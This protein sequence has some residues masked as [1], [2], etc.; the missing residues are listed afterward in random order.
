MAIDFEALFQ[1]ADNWIRSNVFTWPALVQ[2][3]VLLVAIAAAVVAQRMLGNQIERIADRGRRV[4]H[5]SSDGPRWRLLVAPFV[6][7]LITWIGFGISIAAEHPGDLLRITANLL[8][9]WVVIRLIA[10][11]MRQSN[12]ASLLGTVVWTITALAI[13]GWLEPSY[14]FLDTIALDAGDL[15]ISLVSIANGV[16]LLG[17]F[18]I[19]SNLLT[20]LLDERMKRLEGVSATVR[21]LLTKVLRI[22]FI[23]IAF[24]VTLTSIGIDLSVLAIFSGAIGI[25]LGFG[26][27]KVVSNLLSGILLLLDRSL[28][29]GDVIEVGDAYGWIDK[30][31]ARYVTVATRDGKEYLIPNED[32]ITQQVINWSYS[33]RA[34]RVKIAVGVSYGSDIHKAMDLMTEAAMSQSRV[35]QSAAHEPQVRLTEFADSAVN[36]ELRIWLADPEKG[37]MNATSDI[38]LAIWD[39]FHKEGIEFPFPQHDL[40]ITSA[41]GLETVVKD[42]LNKSD[43]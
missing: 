40:H 39:A 14:K 34:I 42:I 24:V 4:L 22:V 20:G 8:T 13:L 26:L 7:A 25:G 12:W 27:Q 1:L 10:G 23:T 38:R 31:G 3:L 35:L 29:P 11:F 2:F 28:K 6:A 37:M 16:I 33:N 41:H 21:V 17:L 15:H 18:L 5:V 43:R 19:V 32:L 9:A 30:M 36:L